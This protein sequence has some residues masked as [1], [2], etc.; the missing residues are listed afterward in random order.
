MKSKFFLHYSYYQ[1]TNRIYQNV[2]PFISLSDA[3]QH[4]SSV[5]SKFDSIPE[6][7][8]YYRLTDSN[9]NV[10]SELTRYGK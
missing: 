7:R 9:L 8:L 2:I 1:G 6:Y 10:I 4:L 5:V 3:F